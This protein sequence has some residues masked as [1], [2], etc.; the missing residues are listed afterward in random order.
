MVLMSRHG[1]SAV[2]EFGVATPFLCLDK[3]ARLLGS[4][5]SQPHFEVVTW[6]VMFGVTTSFL[7]S[8]I[9]GAEVVSRHS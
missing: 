6:V 1:P 9:E 5:V 2:G 3:G 7:V 4:L 8:R